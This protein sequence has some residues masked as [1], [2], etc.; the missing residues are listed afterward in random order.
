MGSW[1]S[2][3]VINQTPYTWHFATQDKEYTRINA[4]CTTSYQEYWESHRFIYFRYENHTQNSFSY[5][6]STRKAG[7]SFT[8]KETPNRS[9][10]QMHCTS[11]G[12][13]HFCPNYGKILQALVLLYTIK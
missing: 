9:Q 5:E 1:P 4:G 11:D 6:F 7:T 10:I 3:S 2:V 13:T 8:L 12:G